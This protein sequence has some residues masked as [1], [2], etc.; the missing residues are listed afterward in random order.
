MTDVGLAKLCRRLNIPIPGRGYWRKLETG[1]RVPRRPSLPARPRAMADEVV[2]WMNIGPITTSSPSVAV[3]QVLVP[4]ML[5]PTAALTLACL[6]KAKPDRKRDIVAPG[7][8]G[9]HVLPDSIERTV[10]LVDALAREFERA[11][12]VFGSDATG[13]AVVARDKEMA[14]FVFREDPITGRLSLIRDAHCRGRKTWSDGVKTRVEKHLGT[15]VAS[16][17]ASLAK[18]REE[19]IRREE[20]QAFNARLS[21]RHDERKEKADA[22]RASEKLSWR[23]LIGWE[24]AMRLRCFAAA[25]E[26]AAATDGDSAPLPKL[27]AADARALADRFDPLVLD[28]PPEVATMDY[29]NFQEWY[30]RAIALL[31]KSDGYKKY[32]AKRLYELRMTPEEAASEIDWEAFWG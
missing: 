10:L 31:G 19:R 9:I 11:G 29:I 18:L 24:K 17:E 22:K 4:E 5:H 14:S 23:A 1:K 3:P 25:V 21:R 12:C 26:A 8:L 16:I 15:F 20:R 7:Y 6:R 28:K 2:A 30:A 27:V 13:R 32:G